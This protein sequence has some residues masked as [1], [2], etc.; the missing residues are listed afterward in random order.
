MEAINLSK[1]LNAVESKVNLKNKTK[2]YGEESS[3]FQKY[4]D[5]NNDIEKMST[6]INKIEKNSDKKDLDNDL[7]EVSEKIENIIQ[8][9]YK[10]LENDEKVNLN[11]NDDIS[12]NISEVILLLINYFNKLDNKNL[13]ESNEAS[14]NNINNFNLKDFNEIDFNTINLENILNI[15][16]SEISNSFNKE[17]IVSSLNNISNLIKGK[18][19]TVD[20]Q[21][22][23][24]IFNLMENDNL[25]K[26][27][28][29]DI[30]LIISDI[31]NSSKTVEEIDKNNNLYLDFENNIEDLDDLEKINILEIPKVIPKEI[32]ENNLKNNNSEIYEDKSISKEEDFLEKILNEDLTN[33]T[34]NYYSK[35]SQNNILN[36]MVGL[37]EPTAISKE[38]MT[39]DIIK[40]IK[41]MVI[42]S[43]K[44][45][46][47]KIYPEEL[48]ELTIK[49]LSEEGIMKAELKAT[50]KE[51]YNLLNANI[52]DIKKSLENQNIKIQEVNIGIY[53]EDT[54][55]FSGKE[56][57]NQ[58]SRYFNED[59]NTS[60]SYDEDEIIEEI[61]L[62]NNINYLA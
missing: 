19:N 13:N 60:Y 24:S 8:K 28:L 48:G 21:N 3:D 36:D 4:L 23:N 52:N 5:K 53:N 14:F 11:M 33:N 7:Q 42:D 30:S 57:Q 62:E 1:K 16:S 39:S 49:I 25:D 50:S 59:I 15:N 10:I 58:N 26:K 37:N 12:E 54:T 6:S 9:I 17:N 56:N 47:V 61:N 22:E 41:Y 51:T 34:N 27:L 44:E 32:S 35:L 46:S 2:D 40:N 43:I 55:F 20:T 18:L 38:N 29:N 31:L 45:L